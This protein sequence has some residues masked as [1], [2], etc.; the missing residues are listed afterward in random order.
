MAQGKSTQSGCLLLVRPL[1]QGPLAKAN[2]GAPP[3]FWTNKET[4][5]KEAN[6][7]ILQ[8]D[9]WAAITC[10]W[11]YGCSVLVICCHKFDYAKKVA[12]TTKILDS[13]NLNLH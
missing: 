8:E 2:G 5:R 4:K 3:Y 9:R 12:S 6:Y 13:Q 7:Q 11:S 10:E 1:S